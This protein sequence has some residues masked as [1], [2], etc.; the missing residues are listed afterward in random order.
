M[1]TERSGGTLSEKRLRLG[2]PFDR[3]DTSRVIDLGACFC[4]FASFQTKEATAA[5][6]RDHSDYCSR[7]VSDHRLLRSTPF[8]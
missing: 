2:A 4:D 5:V 7:K 1:G 3:A 6:S 8:L